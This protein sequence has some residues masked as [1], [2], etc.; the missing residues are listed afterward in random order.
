VL[1][2]FC[3]RR[4]RYVDLIINKYGY[5]NLSYQTVRSNSVITK[6]VPCT[7][8][9]YTMGRKSISVWMTMS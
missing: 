3:R 2:I 8:L 9:R 7:G 4:V 5:K 1:P 6:T